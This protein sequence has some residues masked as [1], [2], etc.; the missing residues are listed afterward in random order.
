MKLSE[1]QNMKK[2]EVRSP[3]IEDPVRLPSSDFRL[4]AILIST[5]FNIFPISISSCP[6][7]H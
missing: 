2:S 6:S 1:G 7:S 4:P 3:K 5:Y